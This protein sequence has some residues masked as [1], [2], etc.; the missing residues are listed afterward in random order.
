[1]PIE[2][3]KTCVTLFTHKVNLQIERTGHSAKIVM[4]KI[5]CWMIRGE[6]T[7]DHPKEEIS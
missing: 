1:M 6:N 4:T 7:S 3:G 5:D 2:A